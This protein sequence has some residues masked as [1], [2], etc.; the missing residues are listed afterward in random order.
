QSP[1]LA[2][3]RGY[4]PKAGRTELR[5]IQK[6]PIHG[7]P[8]DP[9]TVSSELNLGGAICPHL[10]QL[11]SPGAIRREIN[12]LTI[13][14]P[15]RTAFFGWFRR[16]P[17]RYFT[18][19]INGIYIDIGVWPGRKDDLPIVWSAVGTHTGGSNEGQLSGIGPVSVCDPYFHTAGAV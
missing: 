3:L 19:C 16:E 8:A 14:R 2:A 9:P 13:S 7:L 1:L 18:L 10:P 17:P 5:V 6:L 15:G 12:P 11:A 4:S